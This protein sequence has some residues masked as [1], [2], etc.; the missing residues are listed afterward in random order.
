LTFPRSSFAHFAEDVSNEGVLQG[1]CPCVQEAISKCVHVSKPLGQ[2]KPNPP[3]HLGNI[4]LKEAY[5]TNQL[6]ALDLE[7]AATA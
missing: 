4:D 5:R 3:V 6:P 2:R 1:L 7:E